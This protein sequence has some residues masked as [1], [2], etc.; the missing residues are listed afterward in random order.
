MLICKNLNFSY[1]KKKI[2]QNISLEF[3]SG[4]FI[5]LLGRN[6][7]GKSTLLRCLCGLDQGNVEQL[8]VDGLDMLTA[9]RGD[10][11]RLISF[12]P[13]EHED[14]FPFDVLDVVV[15]GRTVFLSTFGAPT[16][17]DYQLA[18]QAL[19]ELN[20][21]H[22]EDRIY[23]T[24]SGGEK[25]LVLLAR[26]LVQSRAVVFLDEPTN[27]LD[28]KNRY[29]MLARLK[30]LSRKDNSCIVACLHDPNHALLFADE[31]VML[32]DGVVIEHGPV[33]EVMTSTAV[34]TLYDIAA[35]EYA[36]EGITTIQPCFAGDAYRGKVL[37]LV[38]ESGS[39]K[40]TI[41]QSVL[42][43]NAHLLTGGVICPGTWKQNKRYSSTI[44]DIKTGASTLFAKRVGGEGDLG[45]FKFYPEGLQLAAGALAP[46]CHADGDLI[47]VDEVGPLELT[48]GGY[49]PHLAPLLALRR[50]SHIWA[51]RPSIVE[52]VITKWMLV[53][54]V[55]VH[56]A[57]QDAL[58]QVEKYLSSR[59]EK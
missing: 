44:I 24:L 32:R 54:P 49:G 35:T 28:Y 1:Q 10:I 23:T 46:E 31:V 47:I 58:A 53:E 13:Q 4:R 11:A 12:V 55:V 6:G 43:Q 48:D 37:L 25:Q 19:Q 41:L 27:H 36:S 29:H 21:G 14:M 56:V 33:D 39:G 40:T 3:K 59:R 2:L 34:S 22:L 16:D 50:P 5:A 26:A 38:G 7:A 30:E 9:Q 18:R 17:F 15:M 8:T 20:M 52:Q 42:D 51:V 57:D 45:P